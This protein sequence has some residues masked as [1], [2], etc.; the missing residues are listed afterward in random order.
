MIILSNIGKKKYYEISIIWI[1]GHIR[2]VVTQ[3]NKEVKHWVDM[4]VNECLFDDSEVLGFIYNRLGTFPNNM[5]Y[6]NEFV[7]KKNNEKFNINWWRK[8]RT[9]HN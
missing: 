3:I 9:L 7:I 1:W 5:I 6:N 8:P 4:I 2:E